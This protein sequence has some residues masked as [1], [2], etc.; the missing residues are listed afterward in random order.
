MSFKESLSE[1]KD[2]DF[3]DLDIQQIGVWPA[4]LKTILVVSIVLVIVGLGYFL[5]VKEISLL[6]ETAA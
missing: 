2:I 6:T 3:A 5:K 4:A 1:L